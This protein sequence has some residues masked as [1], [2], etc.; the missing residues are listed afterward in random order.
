MSGFVLS[1]WAKPAPLGYGQA[2]DAAHFVA[3]PLLASA[4]V[5]LVGVVGADGEKFRWP[6][7]A[8]LMLCLAALAL[9]GSIQ[10]S[11]HARALLYS[12]DDLESWWGSEDL[13]DLDEELRRQ[14]RLDYEQWKSKIDRAV[15]LYNLGVALIGA[16]L[17]LCAAPPPG[18]ALDDAVP[19]WIA[20]GAVGAGAFAELLWAVLARRVPWPWRRPKPQP[21]PGAVRRED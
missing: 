6:G 15:G 12:Y 11:F 16:G 21:A 3:A 19:R 14:Q 5:A 4:A 2:A 1:R 9:V 7:A 8:V 20:C 13:K 10:Q 17:S 18:S